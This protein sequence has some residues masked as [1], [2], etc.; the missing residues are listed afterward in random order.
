[1]HTQIRACIYTY[2]RI[3]EC[4][5]VAHTY[6][7]MYTYYIHTIHT[8]IVKSIDVFFF[9]FFMRSTDL[10]IADV[11]VLIFLTALMK[12]I[13]RDGNIQRCIQKF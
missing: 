2:V 3:Y 13:E 11:A 1:M 6:V 5:Y 9:C 8:Y 10:Y 12:K 4:M 7:C